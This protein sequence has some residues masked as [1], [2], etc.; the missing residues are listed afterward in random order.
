VTR[1]WWTAH[2]AQRVW[3]AFVQRAKRRFGN[4]ALRGVSWRSHGERLL[5]SL[6]MQLDAATRLEWQPSA[7]ELDLDDLRLTRTSTVTVELEAQ[8]EVEPMTTAA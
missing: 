6:G 1:R 2:P 7:S 8:A 5:A 3:K 4:D